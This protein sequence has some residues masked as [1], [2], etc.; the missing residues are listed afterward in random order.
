MRKARQLFLPK[1]RVNDE[2]AHTKKPK[3]LSRPLPS[4]TRLGAVDDDDEGQ[5]IS[6]SMASTSV[7]VAPRHKLSA[8]N[9]SGLSDSSGSSHAFSSTR[10]SSL[11]ARHHGVTNVAIPTPPAVPTPVEPICRSVAFEHRQS[12][13]ALDL[14]RDKALP[15]IPVSPTAQPVRRSS[16]HS[17]IQFP[18]CG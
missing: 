14:T 3:P 13:Q 10:E 8:A 9:R 4:S 1:R 15:N 17:C 7:A 2:I 6:S 12:R 16:L 18:R 5:C 11:P